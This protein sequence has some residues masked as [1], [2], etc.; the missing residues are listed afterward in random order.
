MAAFWLSI[1][2]ALWVPLAAGQQKDPLK[3]F[4]RRFG[5]QTALIDNKFVRTSLRNGAS[6]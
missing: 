5:H 6:S 1:L 4:C 2:A 3:D